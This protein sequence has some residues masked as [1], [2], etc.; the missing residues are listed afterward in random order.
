MY[1][2]IPGLHGTLTLPC[3]SV[4]F[5][6]TTLFSLL[7]TLLLSRD[8][9]E[10]RTVQ[11]GAQHLPG[12]EVRDP[13]SAGGHLALSPGMAFLGQAGLALGRDLEKLSIESVFKP[14]LRGDEL[15]RDKGNP[16]KTIIH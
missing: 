16:R 1:I 3:S 9:E 8:G 14:I 13:D 11:C 2:I 7:G 6:L 12:N 15:G 4:S 10:G 5:H